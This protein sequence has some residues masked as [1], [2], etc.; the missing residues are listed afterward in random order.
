[1]RQNTLYLI[2]FLGSALATLAITSLPAML[3]PVQP[4]AA[5]PDLAVMNHSR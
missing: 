5:V 2:L 3:S 4:H 1:M